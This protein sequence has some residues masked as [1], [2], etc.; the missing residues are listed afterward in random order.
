MAIRDELLKELLAGYEKP[1]DLT[2]PNGLL[3]QL[4][5]ALVETALQA[6]MTDHLGYEK[7]AP[8]GR[9]TGNSRNGDKRED[10]EDRS[11]RGRDRGPARSERD[12]RTAVG[13]EAPD[14]LRRLRRQDHLDVRARD[15]RP[16]D[17]GPPEELYGTEVVA[18]PDLDA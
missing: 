7:H 17:P 6:E 9:G 13:E 3:K 11:R 8:D 12:L 18:R 4:T 14:A 10:A 5:G 15:D 2:G 1:E 16:R